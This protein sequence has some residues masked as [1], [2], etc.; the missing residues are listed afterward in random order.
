MTTE[1]LSHERGSPFTFRQLL[2]GIRG[3]R[4]LHPVI[5]FVTLTQSVMYLTGWGQADAMS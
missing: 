5:N 4:I 1:P 2:E 3:S